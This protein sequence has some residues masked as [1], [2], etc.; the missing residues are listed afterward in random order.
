MQAARRY[1]LQPRPP[2]TGS[3]RDR[4]ERRAVITRLIPLWPSEVEDATVAGRLQLLAKLR[5]AL[6]AERRRGL[7]GHW[8]YDLA[9]HAELLRAYRKELVSQTTL[10]E[11]QPPPS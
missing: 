5:R 2:E 3:W 6:R 8:T 9:R 11:N 4:E 1:R 7:A 10:T